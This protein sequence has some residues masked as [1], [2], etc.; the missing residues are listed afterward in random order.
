MSRFPER[1]RVPLARIGVVEG[2]SDEPTLEVQGQF[3][4]SL[5]ELRAAAEATFPS[6]FD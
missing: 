1:W 2:A 6:L 4:L 5:S 3:R